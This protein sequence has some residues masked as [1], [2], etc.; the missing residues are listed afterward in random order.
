MADLIL[1]DVHRVTPHTTGNLPWQILFGFRDGM[2]TATM[3]DGKLLM[4]DRQLLTLDEE[5]IAAKAREQAQKVW[6]KI[7]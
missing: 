2:V 3:V 5:E 7:D 6:N 4:K 1:W